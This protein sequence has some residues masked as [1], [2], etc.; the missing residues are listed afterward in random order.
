MLLS[1]SF[2]A[3]HGTQLHEVAQRVRIVPDVVHLPDDPNQRLPAA[4]L[5]RIE[6]AMST[7]DIRFSAL[8]KSFGDTLTEAKNLKWAHFH[9]TAI[10][11]HPDRKST[12]LNSSHSQISYAV[13]CLK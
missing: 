11:Q 3:A 12:R 6:V 8:Y 5:D 13:F 1:K 4:D 10:E 7:R 2:V 9:S